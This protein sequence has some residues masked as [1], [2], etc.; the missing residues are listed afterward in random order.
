MGNGRTGSDCFFKKSPPV[1]KLGIDWNA[2]GYESV[3]KFFLIFFINGLSLLLCLD[4][5]GP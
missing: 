5:R 2:V 4:W 3:F 1:P